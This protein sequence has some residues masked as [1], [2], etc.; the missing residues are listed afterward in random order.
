MTIQRYKRRYLHPR[1]VAKVSKNSIRRFDSQKLSYMEILQ[2]CSPT[3]RWYK[4]GRCMHCWVFSLIKKRVLSAIYHKIRRLRGESK[5]FFFCL[6]YGALHPQ[7]GFHHICC[8]GRRSSRNFIHILIQTSAFCIPNQR[9]CPEGEK[10]KKNSTT[11]ST[12][13]KFV[14]QINICGRRLGWCHAPVWKK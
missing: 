6:L 11:T 13:V 12:N 10:R 2:M 1:C 5:Y 14:F 3:H 4:S 9:G 8:L 7:D